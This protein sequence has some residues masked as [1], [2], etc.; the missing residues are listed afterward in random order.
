[1]KW[2]RKRKTLSPEQ[3]NVARKIAEGILSRQRILADYLNQ[4]TSGISA[5]CW[6]CLLSGFCLLC[7]SY[8]L[9]LLAQVFN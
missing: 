6:L 5:C 2:F 9:Y 1:M 7:G 4:K 3:E 8:L